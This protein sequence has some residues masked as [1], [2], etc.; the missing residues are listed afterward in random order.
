MGTLISIFILY[1]S[2]KDHTDPYLNIS[3]P[4]DRMVFQWIRYD[5]DRCGVEWCVSYGGA[6]VLMDCDSW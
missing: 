1:I 6:V 3:F 2:V 5:C 4:R